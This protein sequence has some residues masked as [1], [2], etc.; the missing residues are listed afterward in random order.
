MKA[1][2]QLAMPLGFTDSPAIA[3]YTPSDR[4]QVVCEDRMGMRYPKLVV[5]KA[6]RGFT[7]LEG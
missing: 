3:E 5:N 7:I 2:K 1:C 4:A 6:Q